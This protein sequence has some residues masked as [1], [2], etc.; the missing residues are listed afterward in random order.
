MTNFM[1][2]CGRHIAAWG[3]VPGTVVYCEK[4]TPESSRELVHSDCIEST[5]PPSVDF[6]HVRNRLLVKYSVVPNISHE[7]KLDVVVRKR[8]SKILVETADR[9]P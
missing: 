6:V 1:D 7:V 4:L 2:Q 9:C 3:C 5:E 8:C